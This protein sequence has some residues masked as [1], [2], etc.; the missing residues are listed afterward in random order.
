MMMYSVG[1]ICGACLLTMIVCLTL[2]LIKVTYCLL[3]DKY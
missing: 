2:S 3:T 1:V